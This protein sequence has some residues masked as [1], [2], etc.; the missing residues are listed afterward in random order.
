MP[1]TPVFELYNS[2]KALPYRPRWEPTNS[3]WFRLT[4]ALEIDSVVVEGLELRGGAC[5]SLPDRAVRFMLHYRRSNKIPT[6]LGRIE[7][8]PLQPHTNPAGGPYP[9]MRI[10]GSHFHSFRLNWLEQDSRMRAG[11]L[12]YAQPLN[13]EPNSFEELLAFAGKEFRIK[14][15]EMIERPPWRMPDLFGI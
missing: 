13:H 15:L 10:S 3:T 4:S 9:L 12:P 5:Q 11:N 14:N 7:W 6:P 8:R 1:P 2:D